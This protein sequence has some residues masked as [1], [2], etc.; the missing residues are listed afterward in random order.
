MIRFKLNYIITSFILLIAVM[1]CTPD[2]RKALEATDKAI[3]TTNEIVIVADQNLWDGPLGDTIR[4]YF[5]TPFIILPQPEPLFD[6]RHFT[7]EELRKEPLRK[8]LRTYMFIG[9]LQDNAS[10]TAQLIREDLREENVR[11][12]K[13]DPTFISTA[14]RNKWAQGQLQIYL[15]GFGEAA[16]EENIKKNFPVIAKKVQDFDR[17]QVASAAYVIGENQVSSQ[18]VRQNIGINF[19]VPRDYK[20]AVEEDDF[21]WLRKETREISSNIMLHKIPYTN[22]EQL[23]KEGIKE[24]RNQ[25]GKKYITTE[26]KGAYMR[27][28]D[29]DLP[30]FVETIQL[31]G[32]YALEARGIWDIVNDFMGG[33]FISYLVLDEENG[34]LY[35]ADGFVH[36]PGVQ[37]RDFMQ[38]LEYIFKS[39]KTS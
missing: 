13:E 9:D 39:L 14:G 35:F 17:K 32:S 24:I 3:G 1:S 37:K 6:L 31:N 22:K 19:K 4:Y 30:L 26:I 5:E 8:Q 33:P 25:L 29:E 38:Q 27:I 16:L 34:A 12:A 36:A 18:T 15:F 21:I 11:R 2:Q 23:S 20:I 7:V 28:N 10:S